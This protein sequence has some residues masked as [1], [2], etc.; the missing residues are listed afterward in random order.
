MN[1]T[2]V[3]IFY[4]HICISDIILNKGYALSDKLIK[5][6]IE[7]SKFEV[8][9]RM[10]AHLIKQDKICREAVFDKSGCCNCSDAAMEKCSTFSDLI[11]TFRMEDDR[12]EDLLE[13]ESILEVED[14]FA[15]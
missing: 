6:N 11:N 14:L 9:L 8:T 2:D 15:E 3:L 10:L 7:G 13:T 4:Y 12:I 1:I 5:F